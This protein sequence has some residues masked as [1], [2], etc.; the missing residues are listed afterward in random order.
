MGHEARGRGMGPILAE[1]ESL[2]AEL[3]KLDDEPGSNLAGTAEA[4]AQWREAVESG[5]IAAQRTLIKRTFPHLAA[6]RQRARGDHSPERIKLD[7]IS[8]AATA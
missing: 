6:V 5:D 4:I 1:I 8:R 2:Q 3:A 7:G